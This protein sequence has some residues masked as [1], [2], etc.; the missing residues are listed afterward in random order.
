MNFILSIAHI[1]ALNEAEQLARY[2]RD[3]LGV[4]EVPIYEVPS[5]I[6][7]HAGPKAIAVS[8]FTSPK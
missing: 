7:V 2:F 1:D 6:I 3:T 8:F 4:A 5:A